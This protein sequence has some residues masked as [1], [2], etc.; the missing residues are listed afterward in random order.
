MSKQLQLQINKR[1]VQAKTE[2][3]IGG[4]SILSIT[5]PIDE[6]YWVLRVPVSDTQAIVAFPKF[7][8]L[9]IGFQKEEDWNTNLPYKCDADEIYNHIAH[10][11]GSAKIKKE[12]CIEAIRIIQNAIVEMNL[13]RRE[14]RGIL[15]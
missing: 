1:F 10:N 5:P 2:Y 15:S 4:A 14:K 9:G 11:K 8:T 12:T 13:D 3:I 6:N 7:F